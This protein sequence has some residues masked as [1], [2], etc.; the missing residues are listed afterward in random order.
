MVICLFWALSHGLT[1]AGGKEKS[2][3]QCRALA[4]AHLTKYQDSYA[5]H[6]DGCFPCPGNKEI[7]DRDF[8]VYLQEL[9]QQGAWGSALEVTAFS[10]TVDRPIFLYAVDNESTRTYVFNKQSQRKPLYLKYDKNQEHFTCLVPEQ[11]FEP[12]LANVIEGPHTGL[13]GAA[14]SV[15]STGTRLTIRQKLKCQVS[16]STH[17]SETQVGARSTG[18]RSSVKQKLQAGDQLDDATTETCAKTRTSVRKR[19]QNQGVDRA[20]CS[21][22]F[23][24][25]PR[26][27]ALNRPVD[28]G[29]DDFSWNCTVCNRV[30]RAKTQFLLSKKRNGHIRNVHS[31]KPKS[32]FHQLRVH[33]AAVPTRPVNTLPAQGRWI[34]EYCGEGLPWLVESQKRISIA[35]HFKTCCRAPAKASRKSNAVK[36]RKSKGGWM[37][38][39]FAAQ[40][41]KQ[42]QNYGDQTGHTLHV[43]IGDK[44][45]HTMVTCSVCTRFWNSVA[46]VKRYVAKSGKNKC[47]GVGGR[48]TQLKRKSTLQLWENFPT[49]RQKLAKTWGLRHDERKILQSTPKDFHTVAADNGHK[50]VALPGFRQVQGY[51]VTAYACSKCAQMW[52]S[53]SAFFAR[54][55]QGC[56]V[57]CPG[58]AGRAS[59][60]A[61]KKRFHTWKHWSKKQRTLLSKAWKLQQAEKD[62]LNRPCVQATEWQH[63]VVEDGDVESNPGPS[64]S[65][66][67]TFWSINTR[68]REGA[69]RT[70]DLLASTK[71]HIVALQETNMDK[72]EAQQ[73]SR[74]A[75][76]RGY[77][78]WHVTRQARIDTWNRVHQRGGVSLLVRQDIRAAHQHAALDDCGE[79]LAVDF[80]TISF[81]CVYQRPN[82]AAPG[83]DPLINEFLV[84][85]RP[86]TPVILAGDWNEV[87]DAND[88]TCWYVQQEGQAV[89]SR[90]EG[91]R[92]LDFVKADNSVVCANLHYRPECISDHKIL[93]GDICVHCDYDLSAK[94]IGTRGLHP[95]NIGQAEWTKTLAAMWQPDIPCTDTE[96][97]W[98]QFNS[99]VERTSV[100]AARRLGLQCAAPPAF[101][102]KGSE[103]AFAENGIDLNFQCTCRTFRWRR[104]V[105]LLGRIKEFRRQLVTEKQQPSLL[106]NILRTWPRDLPQHSCDWSANEEIIRQKLQDEVESTRQERFRTWQS[107][108]LAAKKD[109][110]KWLQGHKMI[111]SSSLSYDQNGET[112]TVFGP[113]EGLQKLHDFWNR[114][115]TRPSTMNVD[116]SLNMWQQFGV[117]HDLQFFAL[118]AEDLHNSAAR[119]KGSSGGVDGWSGSE[120]AA[121]PVEIW[122]TYA[123]LL[124]RWQERRQWPQA[125]QHMRQVHIP[126]HGRSLA[127]GSVHVADMR[128]IAV[129]SVLWRVVASAITRSEEPS[130]GVVWILRWLLWKTTS[131]TKKVSCLRLTIPKLSTMWRQSLPLVA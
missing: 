64:S 28:L 68:G 45:K 32:A 74:I 10:M 44:A 60:L 58:T 129:Q 9:A 43:L 73:F 12:D 94:M 7:P 55:R 51:D 93:E 63:D 19:L 57:K 112:K 5:R 8:S 14:K 96:Q 34:C 95:K 66:S 33:Y 52:C 108:M 99:Q 126:K 70:L 38:N 49:W 26:P 125:W 106:N 122:Q 3:L 130:P 77:R 23:S 50:V 107:K 116:E 1:A 103:P 90:W 35:E 113:T 84:G 16:A 101:R 114:I 85:Q 47:P 123:E 76:S 87:P 17:R 46:D 20:S 59:L 30:L 71:P 102:N 24:S 61:S 86:D 88:L 75:A 118:N 82:V 36:R 89:P 56:T 40:C 6:W 2:P 22:T 41:A 78:A 91:H 117:S 81:I 105:K 119:L 111:V 39:D 121:W 31:D 48:R 127:G 124:C 80:C 21:S 65:S 131:T 104:L 69:Y 15:S 110:T 67:C 18:T 100:Q 27:A 37:G 53:P 79:L 97:E 25:V 115:W 109:A 11:H 29:K 92:C 72:E 128:P 120:V 83:L 98:Q 62:K 13:R 42:R 4:V 54:I